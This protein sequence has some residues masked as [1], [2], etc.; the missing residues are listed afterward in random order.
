[1]KGASREKANELRSVVLSLFALCAICAWAT[2]YQDSYKG[3]P[4]NDSHCHGGAQKIP[5]RVECAY[6]DF[7]DEGIAYHDSDC[8]NNGSGAL[9]PADGRYLNQF[10]M[11]EGV[12]TSY[13]KFHDQIGNNPY[14][15]VQPLETSSTS[16]G[17]SQESG[18]RN[19]NL[20]FDFKKA[21]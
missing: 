17:P 20:A 13:T 2:N 11:D 10:R 1:M 6:Y 5:G 18:S 14:N 3:T 12:D 16:A 8:K 9:N 15:R 21:R 4:Y 19:M 7:G